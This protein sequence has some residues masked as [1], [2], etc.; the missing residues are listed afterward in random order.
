VIKD[1]I[2]ELSDENKYDVVITEIGGTTGDIE[3][4]PFLEAIRQLMAPPEKPRRQIGFHVQE[5]APRYR[6]ASR[7]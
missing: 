1:R 3:G 4:L 6:T 5:R 2:R 7:R